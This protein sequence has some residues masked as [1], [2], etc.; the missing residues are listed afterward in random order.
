MASQKKKSESFHFLHMEYEGSIIKLEHDHHSLWYSLCALEDKVP[1]IHRGRKR[2]DI[3]WGLKPTCKERA[4]RRPIPESSSS[5]SH[6]ICKPET[7]WSWP[8]KMFQITW[9][10]ARGTLS[11]E[12]G[13]PSSSSEISRRSLADLRAWTALDPYT[14]IPGGPWML[15]THSQFSERPSTDC[16]LEVIPLAL[17]QLSDLPINQQLG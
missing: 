9:P 10:E 11:L 15:L 1:W 12:W 16:K 5:V 14:C 8:A 4:L 6:H 17:T 7:I 2:L 13:G 3:G